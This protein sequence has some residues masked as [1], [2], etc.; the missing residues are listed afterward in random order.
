M[1]HS[2]SCH[3][4][5]VFGTDD[6]QWVHGVSDASRWSVSVSGSHPIFC[7]LPNPFLLLLFVIL[8][9]LLPLHWD[10]TS[11]S[12]LGFVLHCSIRSLGFFLLDRVFD[13]VPTARSPTTAFGGETCASPPVISPGFWS[14]LGLTAC[15]AA[16]ELVV[17]WCHRVFWWWWWISNWPLCGVGWRHYG[18]C[19]AWW[20]RQCVIGWRRWCCW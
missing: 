5:S 11:P 4:L 1:R 19:V 8:W 3:P 2:L 12:L 16:G 14:V 10:S 6:I 17:L 7:R 18:G 9:L 15:E 13:F 20:L